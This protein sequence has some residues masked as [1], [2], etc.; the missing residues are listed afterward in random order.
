MK[1]FI[2]QICLCCVVYL[3]GMPNAQAQKN[4]SDTSVRV[5]V[6]DM[7]VFSGG[8]YMMYEFI[9][10]TIAYPKAAK[11][12]SIEG[13]VVVTFIV[14]K[15]G[16]I[17]NVKALSGLEGFGLKEEAVRV[18]KL[19]PKFTPGMQNGKPVRVQLN[20]PIAFRLN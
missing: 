18:V 8:D 3:F 17:T 16:S 10:K 9:T 2:W 13:K 1:K 4:D 5:Y 20:I 15:D 19:F 14:E 6:E 12:A 7:P 11:E